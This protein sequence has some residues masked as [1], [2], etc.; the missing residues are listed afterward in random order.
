M[1]YILAILL[2]WLCFFSLGKP[3]HGVISLILQF[4]IVGWPIASVWAFF[5]ISEYRKQRKAKSM[6]KR[7][8]KQAEDTNPT[9]DIQDTRDDIQ[10]E[11]RNDR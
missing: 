6:A 4:S 2:P 11:P 3:V 8:A 5:G 10:E 7:Q 9:T 1:R